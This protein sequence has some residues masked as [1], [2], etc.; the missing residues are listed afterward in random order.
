MSQT[1]SQISTQT[2]FAHLTDLPC[3]KLVC[4]EASAVISLYGAQLLSYQPAPGRELLWLSP[5]AVW[6]QQQAIRGGVPVCWPWFG[7]A[8][9]PFN[10][11]A[12]KLPNHG[13]VRNRLWRQVQAKPSAQQALVT[14]SIDVDDIPTLHNSVTLNLT[15]KLTAD[16]LTLQLDCVEPMLQQAALHS[17]FAVP[18]LS[19]TRVSPLPGAYLDKTLGGE[20]VES[21]APLRFEREI[22]RV[23]PEP[24]AELLLESGAQQLKISQQG[25]DATV[26]WNPWQE[27]SKTLSDLDDDG[28]E[29]FV[30]VETAHLDL[31]DSAPLQLIQSLTSLT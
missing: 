23:Y 7:P 16:T 27:R 31:T 1:L 26:V 5:K 21:T 3:L 4:G 30:C 15:L 22:D 18:S 20:R 19:D 2:G 25:Q 12:A 10:T 24:A 8:G 9:K 11:S 29:H 28:Y 17:Y 13:L 6:Q 14:L